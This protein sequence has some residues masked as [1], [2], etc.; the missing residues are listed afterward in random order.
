MLAWQGVA[1]VEEQ[2]LLGGGRRLL[3]LR[4]DPEQRTGVPIQFRSA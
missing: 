3:S 2:Q 1:L 4:A